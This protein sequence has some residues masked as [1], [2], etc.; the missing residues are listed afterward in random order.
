[1]TQNRKIMNVVFAQHFNVVAIRSHTSFSNLND[2][3]LF[4]TVYNSFFYRYF[5]PSTILGK[6]FVF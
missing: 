3:S 2:I 5:Y 4:N 6:H 1:V